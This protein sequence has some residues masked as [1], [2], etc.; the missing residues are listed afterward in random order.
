MTSHALGLS[1]HFAANVYFNM[2]QNEKTVYEKWRFFFRLSEA[3][4]KEESWKRHS[5]RQLGY[6][7]KYIIHE[8]TLW[9]LSIWDVPSSFHLKDKTSMTSQI[10]FYLLLHVND[11][12]S[13]ITTLTTLSISWPINA[14]LKTAVTT[15]VVRKT[16]TA[17]SASPISVVSSSVWKKMVKK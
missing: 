13:L 4:Q 6:I 8:Y 2:L 16:Q 1:W 14:T 15:K 12:Q 10:S 3:I 11:T 5:C 7:T 17:A 9:S